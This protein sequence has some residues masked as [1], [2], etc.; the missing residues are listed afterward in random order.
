[1]LN[2]KL[3]IFGG[4]SS[5]IN[6]IELINKLNLK[7]DEILIVDD[8]KFKRNIKKVYGINVIKSSSIIR[9]VLNF[10]VC[11]IAQPKLREKINNEIIKTFKLKTLSLIHPETKISS[12]VK[13][14]KGVVIFSGVRI[15]HNSK[16]GNGCLINF[17]VDIGH[18]VKIGSNSVVLTNSIVLGNVKIGNQVMIGAGCKILNNVTIHSKCNIAFATNITKSITSKKTVKQRFDLIELKN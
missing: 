10:G 13:I 6:L 4:G 3:Y 18:D 12:N 5:A 8:N 17:N 15:N 2:R 9:N 11:S 7:F 1:M 16:I 14:G